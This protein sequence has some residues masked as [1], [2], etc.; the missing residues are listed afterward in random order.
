MIFNKS[1]IFSPQ[2]TLIHDPTQ[3]NQILQ[4]NQTRW[5]VTF[6][7][8]I[9]PSNLME[10]DMNEASGANNWPSTYA[11][12]VWFRKF[13][14]V[15][16]MLRYRTFYSTDRTIIRPHVLLYK[17]NPWL[18]VHF[19]QFPIFSYRKYFRSCISQACPMQVHWH[20]NRALKQLLNCWLHTWLLAIKLSRTEV[21]NIFVWRATRAIFKVVAGRIIKI[22]KLWAATRAVADEAP[23]RLGLGGPRASG[24]Q[25]G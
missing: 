21:S 5:T 2:H 18:H 10:R 25:Q 20:W 19:F 1:Y 24:A 15:D 23:G 4:L 12:S 8:S 17:L 7:G 11:C 22:N 9:T 14:T 6:Q 3:N 13:A 16:A